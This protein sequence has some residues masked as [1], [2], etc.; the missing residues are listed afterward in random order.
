MLGSITN[1]TE[2]KRTPLETLLRLRDLL[3]SLHKPMFTQEKK[4][5]KKRRSS[6]AV[7]AHT[8]DP[9]TW[10]TGAGRFCASMV[11]RVNSKTARKRKEKKKEKGGRGGV[12][13][14][15]RGEGGAEEEGREEHHGAHSPSSVE[16][17]SNW[18]ST[19]LALADRKVSSSSVSYTGETR[20][21]SQEQV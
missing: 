2:N 8:S 5:R 20:R 7:V 14:N 6:P 3:F 11:L 9:S 10:E 17:F 15:N 4:E 1:I 18:L 16:T 19:A 21:V 13:S 12:T